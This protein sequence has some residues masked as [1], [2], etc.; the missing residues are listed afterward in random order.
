[1][2]EPSNL[3]KVVSQHFNQ[4][5]LEAML[6]RIQ[7]G[8][9]D[10]VERTFGGP[11]GLTNFLSRLHIDLVTLAARLPEIEAAAEAAEESVFEAIPEQH[12]W[13]FDSEMTAPIVMK[14][15]EL[16]AS[17]DTVGLNDLFVGYYRERLDA[18]EQTVVNRHPDRAEL[19]A[20]A[21]GVHRSGQFALSIPVLLAQADGLS[22]D[23]IG[24]EYFTFRKTEPLLPALWEA[25]K[26]DWLSLAVLR[27]LSRQGR[28]R[29]TSERM[30]P[31]E[32]NRHAILHG[33]DRQYGNEQNSL[34]AISLVNFMC[35]ALDRKH[36]L[37]SGKRL[38]GPAVDK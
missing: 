19:I 17:N 24:A 38:P 31:G 7:T 16:Q 13:F 12:G 8:V 20:A 3:G 22:R 36:A 10:F 21:C 6:N 32:F 15:A 30:R 27:G 4:R 5:E 2:K 26:D 33:I 23:L 28:L 29:S 35:Q 37:L 1:M 14:A 18:I 34:K 9:N 25:V 11:E